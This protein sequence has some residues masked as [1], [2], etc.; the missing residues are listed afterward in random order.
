MNCYPGFLISLHNCFDCNGLVAT[1]TRTAVRDQR[2]A[3]L[4]AEAFAT[5]VQMES[6]TI[7]GAVK[8]ITALLKSPE[9]RVAAIT[10]MGK[11]AELCYN[12]VR[13][14]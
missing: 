12:K 14:Q 7:Q 3:T 8:T 2:C 9:K 10:M 13:A 6:L 11:T 4:Q 1:V 5:L